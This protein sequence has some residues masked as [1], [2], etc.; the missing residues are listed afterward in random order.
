LSSWHIFYQTA[1]A[2]HVFEVQC[3]IWWYNA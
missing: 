3:G 2:M 1:S